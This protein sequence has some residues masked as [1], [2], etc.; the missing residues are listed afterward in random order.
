MWRRD[1][2]DGPERH[3]DI[4][5]A[6]VARLLN[7]PPTFKRVMFLDENRDEPDELPDDLVGAIRAEGVRLGTR[8]EATCGVCRGTG[9]V[10][11]AACSQCQAG[12]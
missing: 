12:W 4:D 7:A 9:V 6:E 10:D 5:A 2:A 3:S 8:G 11:G 1:I